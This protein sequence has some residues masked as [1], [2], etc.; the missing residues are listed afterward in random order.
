MSTLTAQLEQLESAQLVL[1]LLEEEL[2]Y[3][4]KHAL[5]QESAYESLLVKKRREI[6]REVAEAF[7][8]TYPERLDEY[9]AVLAAHYAE[10]GDDA[11]T[12]TYALRAG[13]R[14]A[15][16]S[17]YVEARAYFTTAL[18]ALSR[19]PD[20]EENRRARVD[21]AI[22]Q[23]SIAW[24]IDSVEEN[25]SR[26]FAAEALAETLPE[27]DRTSLA[28][29]RYWIGRLY[30]YSN[31]H[32]KAAR[33]YEQVESAARESGDSELFGLAAALGGRT[34]FIQGYFG[35]AVPLLEQ[36]IA[37]FE[38]IGNWPEWIL[39]KVSLAISLAGQGR[40]RE[41][42]VQGEEAIQKA[43]ESNDITSIASAR[44]MTARVDFM[45]GDLQRMLDETREVVKQVGDANPLVL[46]MILG[47]EAWAEGRL[48]LYEVARATMNSCRAA[49]ARL[50]ARLIFSDWFA[51]AAAEIELNAGR[52]DRALVLAQQAVVEAEAAGSVFGEGIAQRVW[53]LALAALNGDDQD[54]AATR[55][56]KS[57]QLLEEGDAVIEVA[58]TQ[59]A[60]G[61]LLEARGR[62]EAAREH[63]E[64]AAAQ[65]EA[66]GLEGE[67]EQTMRLIAGLSANAR[68]LQ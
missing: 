14:A 17:A 6:H 19:L 22:R 66:L 34:F 55:L 12:F 33:Y 63:L 4:F 60:W 46:Y 48:G 61:K 29:V 13:D 38:G 68:Q 53:G 37:Y 5:T 45:A 31:E 18:Q 42:R 15:S 44:G 1:R 24:G 20:S 10:A 43:V 56:Q 40:Y 62:N 50:G 7:E 35:K 67:L 2:A 41:G 3:Q 21:T 58:R 49:A 64:K 59:I 25:L 26:L 28:R 16:I 51:A 23:I 32:R 52:P 30:S 57:L 27:Q 65:F 54:K 11:R 47:F 8:R 39:G 9:A 36:A